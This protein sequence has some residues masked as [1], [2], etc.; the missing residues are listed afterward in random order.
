MCLKISLKLLPADSFLFWYVS[1]YLIVWQIGKP[2]R[3]RKIL[4]NILLKEEKSMKGIE[5]YLIISSFIFG[6]EGVKKFRKRKKDHHAYI[7]CDFYKCKTSSVTE[8][9][10]KHMK[11]EK[12]IF[13]MRRVNEKYVKYMSGLSRIMRIKKNLIKIR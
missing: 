5:M 8:W 7:F 1:L 4:V 2:K 13:K 12:V 10:K 3:D 6:R 11:C 9:K